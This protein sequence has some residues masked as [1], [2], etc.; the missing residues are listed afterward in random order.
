[1]GINHKLRLSPTVYASLQRFAKFKADFHHVF[2]R[3]WKDPMESWHN[4]P[5]LATDDV[6]FPVLKSW[7]PKWCAAIGSTVETNKSDAQCKK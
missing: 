3:E 5:Y 1:M 2:I 7:M 4:L 6:I